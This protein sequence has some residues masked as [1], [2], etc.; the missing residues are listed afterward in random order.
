MLYGENSHKHLHHAV[1]MECHTK[2][3][4]S[5]SEIFEKYVG[6][7]GFECYTQTMPED[8]YMC[9]RF[10]INWAVGSEVIIH[11]FGHLN[12]LESHNAI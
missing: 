5:S 4:S 6:H 9:E 10:L 8:F 2:D 3:G 11:I 1:A 7:P 12:T